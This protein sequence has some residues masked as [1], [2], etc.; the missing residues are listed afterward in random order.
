M[1][2]KTPV[3][4]SLYGPD[5]PGAAAGLAAYMNSLEAGLDTK[6][7]K[8]PLDGLSEDHEVFS[9]ASHLTEYTMKTQRAA[10]EASLVAGGVSIT[11]RPWR[12]LVGNLREGAVAEPAELIGSVDRAAAHT[13]HKDLSVWIGDPDPESGLSRA[14]LEE[15]G[16]KTVEPDAD[17]LNRFVSKRVADL[18]LGTSERRNL[19]RLAAEKG[20]EAVQQK[21][22][23]AETREDT[24]PAPAKEPAEQRDPRWVTVQLPAECVS[25]VKLKS[26]RAM[27]KGILP[28]GVSVGDADLSGYSFLATE[29]PSRAERLDAGQPVN[30]HFREDRPIR[31]SRYD[32]DKKGIVRAET[33][34]W[35]LT[36]A[37]K[38][39]REDREQEGNSEESR[40]ADARPHEAAIA[41]VE[42]ANDERSDGDER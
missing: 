25:R 37:V 7:V 41:P 16:V 38:R 36:R 12:T 1:S 8:S 22:A 5:A 15:L 13:R 18:L 14:A 26:G 33:E 32:R 2:D 11:D 21:E 40:D 35:D 34:P 29:S 10:E 28:E 42:M 31:L 20:R 6:A 27:L 23:P 9:G 24:A 4:V 19:Q 3:L 30:F 39:N 17:G